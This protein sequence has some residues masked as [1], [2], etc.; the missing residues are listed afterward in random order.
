MTNTE[1]IESLIERHGIDA[2]KKLI[3]SSVAIAGLGGLGSNV[4]VCLARAGIGH[5]FIVDFDNVDISNLNRQYYFSNDIGVPKTD[6]LENILKKINPIIKI[7]KVQVKVT[8]ENASKLFG[9]YDIVCECFDK[10][11]N[12][13][14]LINTLLSET[15][16]IT[17]VSG[18]GMA[19]YSSAN[20]I[21][22][23]KINDRLYI[24]GDGVSDVKD[25]LPLF[26]SRVS[27]CAGHQANMVLRL[28]LEREE[29]ENE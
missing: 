7:T 28:L 14:M 16:N 22:T 6:A 25:G 4:A 10:A 9:G 13:A 17:V 12:K 26:A 19:G 2:Y 8:E 18:N 23:K 29:I 21:K 20:K 3:D 24:C 5:L 15:D 27:V 11:E 1:Y